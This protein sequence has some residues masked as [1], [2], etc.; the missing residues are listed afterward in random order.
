MT[1]S[2]TFLQTGRTVLPK[3]TQ[4]FADGGHVGGEQPSGGLDATALGALHQAQAINYFV[5]VTSPSIPSFSCGG[6]AYR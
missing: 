3:A 1:R 6:Q 2:A 4:P 5:V